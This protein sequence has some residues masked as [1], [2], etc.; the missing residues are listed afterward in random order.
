MRRYH[1]P[2][3][4]VTVEKELSYLQVYVD[5]YAHEPEA[6]QQEAERLWKQ[7]RE[8]VLF[9]KGIMSA[10]ERMNDED[11]S[12]MYCGWNE[13]PCV[14][15]FWPKSRYPH[16]TFVWDNYFL[17]CDP[18]NRKKSARF[19]I[20]SHDQPLLIDLVLEDPHPELFY[21][22]SEGEYVKESSSQSCS[23]SAV[24]TT[25]T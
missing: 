4:E 20:D 9:S 18:C 22:L 21:S 12:C 1:R 6:H 24:V 13:A 2:A 23:A 7:H 25:E 5:A 8:R 14:D 3:L 11:R 10:L 15:H 19:P 16:R 17:S